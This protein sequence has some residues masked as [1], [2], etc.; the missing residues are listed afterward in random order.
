MRATEILVV[1]DN[2]G[3]TDLTSEL[4]ARGS[5]LSHTHTASDGLDAIAFLRR[6]GRYANALPPDFVI[7]DLD[8]PKMDGCGVLAEVK[9]DPLLRN[10]PIVM[11]STSDSRQDVL[12]CYE[13]VA[14]CYVSKPGNLQDYAS[15]VTSIVNFWLSV[16]RLPRKEER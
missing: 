7:L 13:L 4:L 1:D 14:N 6:Q 5:S 8:M 12:R 2:P 15:A 3:D 16:A 10:I 11:F 9:A